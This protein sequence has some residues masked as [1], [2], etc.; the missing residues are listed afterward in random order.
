M[1]S[2]TNLLVL[3]EEMDS[4]SDDAHALKLHTTHP[5]SRHRGQLR[6]SR[7]AWTIELT[8]WHSQF[9]SDNLCLDDAFRSSIYVLSHLTWR[10]LKSSKRRHSLLPF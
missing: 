7:F 3:A 9:S 8:S 4:S 10:H 5:V 2:F 6:N 1:E